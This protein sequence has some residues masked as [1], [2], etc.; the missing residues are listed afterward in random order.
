M[1][2]WSGWLLALSMQWGW[3]EF[4]RGCFGCN[5]GSTWLAEMSQGR[6]IYP[7]IVHQ[8]LTDYKRV[9][10]IIRKLWFKTG[11]FFFKLA[12]F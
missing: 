3:G 2:K 9:G 6:E 5:F 8:G 12:V 11:A 4:S 10:E 1:T 7:L